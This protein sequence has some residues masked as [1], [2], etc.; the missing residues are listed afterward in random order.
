[1]SKNYYIDIETGVAHI[2]TDKTAADLAKILAIQKEVEYLEKENDRL[3][4]EIADQWSNL[5]H[6]A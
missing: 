2:V 1:M 4:T 6:K 3:L 5:F